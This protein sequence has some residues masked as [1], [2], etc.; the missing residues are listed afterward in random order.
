EQLDQASR[1]MLARFKQLG[2]AN[3][4]QEA[5]SIANRWTR[6]PATRRVFLTAATKRGEAPTSLSLAMA[7]GGWSPATEGTV[8]GPLVGVAGEKVEDL[9][10][11]KGKLKGAIVVLGKPLE[12]QPPRNPL[13]TPWGE[14][15]IPIAFPKSD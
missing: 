13:L 7:T 4:H 3:A 8:K 1:W 9:Q 6:G 12:M 14:E 2:L 5:R 11:Y 10:Q 15:T